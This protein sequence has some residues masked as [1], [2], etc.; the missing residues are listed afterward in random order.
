MKQTGYISTELTDYAIDWLKQQRPAEKPFL[1]YL[2]LKAVHANFTPEDKYEN[3]LK[4]LPFKRPES[5]SRSTNRRPV[6][7]TITYA[8]AAAIRPRISRHRTLWEN[9]PTPMPDEN[10]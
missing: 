8:A 10:A 9:L 6:S 1:L 3:S 4:D 5:E 7:K 2:S